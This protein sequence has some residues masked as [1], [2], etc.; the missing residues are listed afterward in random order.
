MLGNVA[1]VGWG[2]GSFAGEKRSTPTH[3]K[4]ALSDGVQIDV[5]EI[6]RDTELK[7]R[8][9]LTR[10]RVSCD[11]SSA[12]CSMGRISVWPAQ[13]RSA[14]EGSR[15]RTKSLGSDIEIR[16]NFSCL[17]TEAHSN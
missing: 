12:L 15:A 10:S 16:L 9:F 1:P 7:F 8:V 11:L 3:A 14:T 5:S 2:A 6:E 17:S 4:D 13:M